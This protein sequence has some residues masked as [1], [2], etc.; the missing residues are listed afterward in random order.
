MAETLVKIL[1]CCGFRRTGK[2]M[3]GTSLSMLVDDMSTNKC[4]S[5]VRI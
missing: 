2:A 4:F 3:D 1:L 5:R